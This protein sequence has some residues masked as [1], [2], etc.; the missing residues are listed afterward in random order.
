MIE[1]WSGVLNALCVMVVWIPIFVGL[2]G[3]G[4]VVVG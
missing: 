3:V 4:V 1:C 2:V